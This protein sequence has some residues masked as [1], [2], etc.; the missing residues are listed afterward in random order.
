LDTKAQILTGLVTGALAFDLN[1]LEGMEVVDKAFTATYWA[2]VWGQDDSAIRLLP[3]LVTL[4]LLVIAFCLGLLAIAPRYGKVQSLVFF[5]GIAALENGEAYAAKVK[6]S[7]EAELIQ[8]VLA[9]T[10]QLARIADA[11]SWFAAWATNL[12]AM[13]LILLVLQLILG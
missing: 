7:S 5:G 4:G 11:K 8:A 6:G 1:R 10:F 12:F 3:A 9:D 13:G 2:A